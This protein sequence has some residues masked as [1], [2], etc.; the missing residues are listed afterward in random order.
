MGDGLGLNVWGKGKVIADG[1]L[2]GAKGIQIISQQQHSPKEYT[3]RGR[4]SGRFALWRND[5]GEICVT[6]VLGERG[7]R[8]GQAAGR[9]G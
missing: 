3:V 4:M 2:G 1:S 5:A 7:A 9:R 6:C 8:G